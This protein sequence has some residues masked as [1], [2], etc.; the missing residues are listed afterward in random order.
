MK[1]LREYRKKLI[2]RLLHAARE[3]RSAC[4]AVQDPL[5]PLEG[6][7]SVHQIAVHTRDVEKLVYGWRVRR[8]AAEENPEF[9]NFD[10]NTYLAEHYAAGESLHEVLDGLVKNTEELVELLGNLPAEAWSRVS[11][12]ATLGGG[13]T[14]QTWAERGLAHIEEH[15]ESIR[16]QASL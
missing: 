13:L 15:L 11:R 12:H 6:G 14:L 16:K 3:F 1:E 10:G 2:K 8:T 9:P 7:W 4:L 5:A